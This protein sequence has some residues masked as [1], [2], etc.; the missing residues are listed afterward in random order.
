[1]THEHCNQNFFYLIPDLLTAHH[2]CHGTARKARIFLETA[3]TGMDWKATAVVVIVVDAV[4]AAAGIA[5][6]VAAETC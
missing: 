5:A 4:A 3:E 6:A 2:Y 1:M